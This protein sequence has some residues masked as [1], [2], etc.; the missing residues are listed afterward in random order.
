LWLPF[1]DLL[2]AKRWNIWGVIAGL[3]HTIYEL[4]NGRPHCGRGGIVDRLN[5]GLTSSQLHLQIDAIYILA[6][7]FRNCPIC[8]LGLGER[9]KAATGKELKVWLELG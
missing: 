7:H 5:L 9:Y 4:T 2:A 1:W 8:G 6:M 3:C